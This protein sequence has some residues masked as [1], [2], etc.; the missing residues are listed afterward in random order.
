MIKIIIDTNFL[1]VP[2]QFNVDIF[3]EFQRLFGIYE[4]YIIDKTIQELEKIKSLGGKDKIAANIGLGLIENQKI[5]IINSKKHDLNNNYVD[6]IIINI[7]KKDNT[8]VVATN[9]IELKDKLKKSN[10]K[11]IR[12]RQKK[13]LD[14]N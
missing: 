4:C 12:L 9:D 3:S 7:C 13:Y 10:I 11:I 5:S 1:L 8:Y 2:Y 14:C 6:N